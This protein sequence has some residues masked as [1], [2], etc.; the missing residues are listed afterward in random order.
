M[1]RE[2]KF[3]PKTE[4]EMLTAVV[5]VA[6]IAPVTAGY[7]SLLEGWKPGTAAGVAVLVGVWVL[8]ALPMLLRKETAFYLVTGAATGA[9]LGWIYY[10][11]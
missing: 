10:V 2:V 1:N 4:K 9:A 3:T 5:T 7:L 8:V 11:I 6:L